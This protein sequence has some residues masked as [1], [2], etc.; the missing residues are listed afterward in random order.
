[1]VDASV[2]DKELP[3]AASASLGLSTDGAMLRQTDFRCFLLQSTAV[4]SLATWTLTATRRIEPRT[5]K[6]SLPIAL[7]LLCAVLRR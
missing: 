5:S 4:P 6:A 3:R 2:L 1:M 7:A